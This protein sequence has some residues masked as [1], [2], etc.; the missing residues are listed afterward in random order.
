VRHG[1][2]R[3]SAHPRACEAAA[4][5]TTLL[6]VLDQWLERAVQ[7]EERRRTAL[8]KEA[9]QAASA[10]SLGKWATLVVSNLYRIEPLAER[11]MVEDWEAGGKPVQLK[12]NPSQ[13][14]AQEQAEEAFKKARRLR[15]GSKVVAGASG[16]TLGCPPLLTSSHLA[17]TYQS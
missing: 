10:E 9:S 16:L 11:A 2:A 15:R 8:Q 5:A 6:P 3:I 12:L 7:S 4:G 1:V 17:P 13:G 14:T